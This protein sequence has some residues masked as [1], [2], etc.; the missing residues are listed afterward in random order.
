VNIN[1][2]TTFGTPSLTLSTSNSSGTGGALRADD[3]ILVY[4]T[5]A[6]DAITFGQSGSVGSAATASRRD[7][8]HAMADFTIASD[9]EMQ[10]ATSNTILAPPGRTNFLP[11]ATK[12]WG[13]SSNDGTL[14]TPS[15]NLDSMTDGGTGIRTPVVT[16]DF[17][18]ADYAIAVQVRTGGAV[19]TRL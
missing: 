17:T 4:D 16:N 14:Q 10:A 7:H 2:P 8:A 11:S 18:D 3:T 15:Y 13:Y 1:N 9:A 5:T 19:G 6:V 12:L